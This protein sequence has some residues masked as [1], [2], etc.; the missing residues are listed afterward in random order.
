MPRESM[1]SLCAASISDQETVDIVTNNQVATQEYQV[2]NL[3]L[4][5]ELEVFLNELDEDWHRLP[6]SGAD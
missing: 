5:N 6:R 3:T 4:L 1:G 2:R